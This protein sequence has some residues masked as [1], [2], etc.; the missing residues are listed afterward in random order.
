MEDEPPDWLTPEV[1]LTLVALCVRALVLALYCRQLA[2][3]LKMEGVRGRGHTT[4]GG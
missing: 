1:H 4:S 2:D 3:D